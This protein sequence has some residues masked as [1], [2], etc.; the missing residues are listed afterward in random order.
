MDTNID[1]KNLWKQQKINDLNLEDLLYKL[2]KFKND[3][4]R[5]IIVTNILLSMTCAFI[6]FIWCYYQPRLVTTKFGIVLT[7]LA[8][9]IYLSSYNKLFTI[10]YKIDNSQSNFEY[11]QSLYKVKNKQ[12]FMQTTMLNAYI[13]IL[14]IG[15]CLYIYEYASEMTLVKGITAYTCTLLWIGINWFYIRPKTI[16]KQQASLNELINKFEN[17]NNQLKDF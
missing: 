15:I 16:K 7:I 2:K 6:I 9:I 8:M 1:F 10:F 13:I 14:S 3:H 11:L 12:K 4:L 17:I 5:K